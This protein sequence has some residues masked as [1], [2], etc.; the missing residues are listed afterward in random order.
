LAQKVRLVLSERQWKRIEK[1][2]VGKPEDPGGTGANNRMFVEAVLWI[3]RTGSPWR[4][5]PPF[6][7]VE[8][9]FRALQPVERRRCLAA[10][11]RRA[12]RRSGLRIPDR[13][14]HHRAGPPACG[15]RKRGTQSQAIGRS[16]GGLTSKIHLAVR[17]LGLPVRLI[18]TAGQRNDITQAKALIDGLPAQWVL[19]DTAFDADHFRADIRAINAQAVIPSH[20]SRAK[21]LPLDEHIYKERHLVEC[22]FNE[23]KHFR[24]VATRYE[25]TARNFLAFITVSAIALWLR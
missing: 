14:R 1:L 25:K 11:L 12:G 5:L 10:H 18:L 21:K 4:D 9:R 22:C 6:W 19:G 20:P 24:R 7:Q 23:L 13:R 17:G 15:W 2:C 3:A 16:R 8:Q